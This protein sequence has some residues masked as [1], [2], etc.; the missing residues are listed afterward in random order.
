MSS[1]PLVTLL[2]EDARG[3]LR[4]FGLHKLIVASVWDQVGEA[5]ERHLLERALESRCM[6]GVE[7]ILTV[8]REDLADI[9]RDG[10]KVA[11]VVDEDVIREKLN[12][13]TAA[14]VEEIKEQIR[15]ECPPSARHQ[16]A[17]FVLQRNTETVLAATRDCARECRA[18]LDPSLVERA[19]RKESL[20]RDLLLS[21]FATQAQA[22]VRQ[23]V[24]KKVPSLGDLVAWLCQTINL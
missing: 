24:L 15:G 11:A 5:Q 9:A 23:C 20:A 12:L 21:R 8:C 18:E 7:R 3:Q 10:R 17:V 13:S 14:S 2:Y 19:L 6:K 22:A 16:L 4:E 1:R